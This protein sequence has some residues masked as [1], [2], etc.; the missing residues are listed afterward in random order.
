[1]LKRIFI[2]NVQNN[3]EKNDKNIIFF[4]TKSIQRWER[5]NIELWIFQAKSAKWIAEFF[6]GFLNKAVILDR[7]KYD[8]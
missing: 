3:F 7:K 2:L 1:M 4:F 8:L 6:T 5:N